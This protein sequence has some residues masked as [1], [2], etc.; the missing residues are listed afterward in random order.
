MSQQKPTIE[1]MHTHSG[2]QLV[3]HGNAVERPEP[4]KRRRWPYP[5]L[6]LVAILATIA[7]YFR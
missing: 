5:L 2:L 1:G 7:S 3:I 6:V 4:A